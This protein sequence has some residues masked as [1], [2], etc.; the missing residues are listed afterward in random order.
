MKK[1]LTILFAALMMTAVAGCNKDKDKD[2]N[3]Q[4]EQTIA[5]NSVVY[6]GTT[7]HMNTQVEW[8]NA[9]MT[10]VNA[11]SVECIDEDPVI[12]FTNIHLIPEVWNKTL[13]IASGEVPIIMIELK[14]ENDIFGEFDAFVSGTYSV[15]GNNDGTPVTITLDGVL[16][17]G[18]SLKMKLVTD[19]YSLM[20]NK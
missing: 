20:D 5:D 14:A 6:N 4:Q 15:K 8:I 16:S 17:N 18:K 12:V 3:N 11:K 13:D 19:S 10:W 9:Q 7:Y 1:V 2:N